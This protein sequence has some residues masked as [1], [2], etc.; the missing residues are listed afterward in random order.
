[1]TVS[2]NGSKGK[3]KA[4]THLEWYGLATVGTKEEDHTSTSS[5]V[6]RDEYNSVMMQRE[7]EVKVSVEKESIRKIR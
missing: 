5:L 6:G 4:N 7:V 3:P 1:M 2:S